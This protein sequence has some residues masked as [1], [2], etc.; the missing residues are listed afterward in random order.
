M[1]SPSRSSHSAHN[2]SM[3]GKAFMKA[4]P[5]THP[6]VCAQRSVHRAGCPQL[7]CVCC[8]EPFS[9]VCKDVISSS[10]SSCRGTSLFC[11]PQRKTAGLSRPLKPTYVLNRSQIS[12]LPGWPPGSAK[13]YPHVTC[14]PQPKPHSRPSFVS[15]TLWDQMFAPNCLQVTTREYTFPLPKGTF[16]FIN[17]PSQPSC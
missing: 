15:D 7:T 12:V 5:S 6:T 8:I 14:L 3:C 1:S 11:K 2:G 17:F 10:L 16:C 9:S 4:G 13:T